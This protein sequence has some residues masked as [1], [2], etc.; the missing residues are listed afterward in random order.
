MVIERKSRHAVYSKVPA[1][2]MIPRSDT[3]SSP[4]NKR[5]GVGPLVKSPVFS[6]F[7]ALLVSLLPAPSRAALAADPTP[8]AVVDRILEAA[9]ARQQALD[10]FRISWT[11]QRLVPKGGASS[12]RPPGV[13]IPPVDMILQSQ[14]SLLVQ[15]NR[16]A[17][18]SR[19]QKW[20][21]FRPEVELQTDRRVFDGRTSR[22]FTGMDDYRIPRGSIGRSTYFVAQNVPAGIVFR[23]LAGEFLGVFQERPSL[24]PEPVL[25]Q[26]KSCL[27]VRPPRPPLFSTGQME[28]WIDPERDYVPLKCLETYRDRDDVITH[29]TRFSYRKSPEGVWIPT[30]WVVVRIDSKEYIEL[31][32][33]T[34]TRFEL[35]PTI[36]ADEF[37][38]SFP[39]GTWV[40]DGTDK[41][42]YI[43][44]PNGGKRITT[45]EEGIA[46]YQKIMAE[47][48]SNPD[49]ASNPNRTSTPL[50]TFVIVTM[51]VL[52]LIHFAVR[53]W[54]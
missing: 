2:R 48:A 35:N 42:E 53:R 7:L 51:M 29:E 41:T 50:G 37:D 17:Y 32:R 25:R 1:F 8:A 33:A 5:G 24:N 15:R 16:V 30:G 20:A 21:Q 26:E 49:P 19:R 46:H 45:L 40:R 4:P 13:D 44:T 38:W 12:I 23:P 10:S 11:T 28:L 22:S 43:V 6:L 52:V 34:V 18:N 3:S 9:R 39:P 14:T 47:I 36:A 54:A 27:V 31:E